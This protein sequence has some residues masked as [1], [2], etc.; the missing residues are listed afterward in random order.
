MTHDELIDDA[1]NSAATWSEDERH[2]LMERCARGEPMRF[3]EV[4]ENSLLRRPLL[5]YRCLYPHPL[6]IDS[7]KGRG[8]DLKITKLDNDL[9]MRDLN[10]LKANDRAWRAVTKN[11]PWCLEELYLTRL[12]DQLAERRQ[13][14][15]PPPRGALRVHRVRPRLHPRG[16]RRERRDDVGRHADV[17]RARR[18]PYGGGRAAPGARRPEAR[19]AEAPRRARTIVD[20]A[21]TAAAGRTSTTSPRSTGGAYRR[22]VATACVCFWTRLYR[23]DW[24]CRSKSD[25]GRRATPRGDASTSPAS[26]SQRSRQQQPPTAA[27]LA[28]AKADANIAKK[29]EP[30]TRPP[31]APRSAQASRRAPGTRP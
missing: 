28:R 14:H 20:V 13:Q 26:A 24:W 15:A 8:G 23:G 6:P 11:K 4:P 16:L 30:I 9:A 19:H 17:Q 25:A 22:W 21:A 5:N 3:V 27:Q 12:R 1:A 29:M 18:G 31:P 2:A 7:G 10:H